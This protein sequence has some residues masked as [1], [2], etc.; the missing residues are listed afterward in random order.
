MTIPDE[1]RSSLSP[2]GAKAAVAL[3]RPDLDVFHEAQRNLFDAVDN[4]DGVILLNVAENSLGWSDIKSKIEAITAQ[5]TLPDWVARYT[6][7][8]G[9]PEVLKAV[10]SFMTKHLTGCEVDPSRLVL[11]A[12]AMSAMNI[13]A[14]LL[15]EPDDVVAIPSPSYPVY[16]HDVGAI[17]GLARYNVVTHHEIDDIGDGPLLTTS[18]LD[19][20]L[21]DIESRGKRLRVVIL[22]TPDN[23]TGGMLDR[24]TLEE[25]AEWCDQHRIHLIVN[26]IYGLSLIDTDHPELVG[27]YP[28]HPEFVSFAQILSDR[29]SDYLHYSYA[30]SKDFGLSGF[31]FG[32]IYSLNDD[33]I[34]ASGLLN[35][36]S[37]TSNLTQWVM[38][39]LLEDDAFVSSFISQNKAN[40]TAAYADVVRTLRR[41]GVPYVPSRGG[42]F[43]W[44]DFSEFLESDTAQGAHDLWMRI[45]Q[46]AN[47][48]LTPGEGFGHTKHGLL[49]IVYPGTAPDSLKLAL[50]RLEDFIT[51]ERAV[52]V[53]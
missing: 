14:Q 49:R 15:G 41:C 23:P 22:T 31:R 13:S 34:R 11:T 8:H 29:A 1:Q 24:N 2:R 6:D 12:G 38:Q 40:L 42:L 18:H 39:K 47:V 5:Q 53:G 45:Y 21:E 20:A 16:T 4:P 43:V 32:L 52:P 25:V 33:F 7:S 48:L 35:T 30:L 37:M 27:D 36:F 50:K 10:S 3:P 19:A 51:A 9:H 28:T 26:E 46:G 44:A 17:A